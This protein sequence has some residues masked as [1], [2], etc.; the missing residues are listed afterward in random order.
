[1]RKI[2]QFQSILFCQVRLKLKAAACFCCLPLYFSVEYNVQFITY[3][4]YFECCSSCFISTRR[5]ISF[6]SGRNLADLEQTKA[7]VL[8]IRESN[9][10]QTICDL[11]VADLSL[12][13]QYPV[14]L[15]F[16][17][18]SRIISSFSNCTDDIIVS[19]GSALPSWSRIWKDS[20]Y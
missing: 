11:V 2:F 7:E 19:L 6:L 17:L 4:Y 12:V 1:M 20:F 9:Q 16:R 3:F 18:P 13:A 5:L 14:I 8:S 10:L 15:Y